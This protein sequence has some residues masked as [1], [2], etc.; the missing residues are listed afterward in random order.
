MCS[1]IFINLTKRYAIIDIDAKILH[2]CPFRYYNIHNYIIG[3]NEKTKA[4]CSL[5]WKFTDIKL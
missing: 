1:S 2:S 3:E 5:K 4:Q